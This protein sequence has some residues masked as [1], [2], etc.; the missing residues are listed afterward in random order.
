MELL[1]KELLAELIKMMTVLKRMITP[2]H[3]TRKSL[4]YLSTKITNF[5]L[6]LSKISK[7]KLSVLIEVGLMGKSLIQPERETRPE[8]P[9]ADVFLRQTAVRVSEQSH[10]RRFQTVHHRLAEVR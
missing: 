5:N 2:I 3:Y 6:I 9:S 8:N 10:R 7:V 1:A 4:F